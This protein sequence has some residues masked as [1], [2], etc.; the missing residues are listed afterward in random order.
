MYN[1]IKLGWMRLWRGLEKIE[2][3]VDVWGSKIVNF[4]VSETIFRLREGKM[5]KTRT[6]L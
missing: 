3:I 5:L 6:I 4:V 2:R 1:I